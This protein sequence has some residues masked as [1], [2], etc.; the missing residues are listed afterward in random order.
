MK[1]TESQLRKIVKKEC[2]HVLSEHHE[3]LRLDEQGVFAALKGLISSMFG[4]LGDMLTGTTTEYQ[5]VRVGEAEASVGESQKALGRKEPKAWADLK[6]HDDNVDKA[7]WAIAI[8]EG[9]RDFK[10]FERIVKAISLQSIAPPSPEEADEWEQ[11]E[12][13]NYLKDIYK[14]IGEAKGLMEWL[15]VHLDS[16]KALGDSIDD[17]ASLEDLLQQV[18]DVGK[19]IAGDLKSGLESATEA[20]G[21]AGDE[22]YGNFKSSVGHIEGSGEQLTDVS[23]N[24][25]T[26]VKELKEK[27]EE[28]AAATEEG[29]ELEAAAQGMPEAL[30]RKYIR[31]LLS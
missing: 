3:E 2:G 22:Y 17:K 15:G 23:L 24:G 6:P 21:N 26:R 10:I 14:G 28:L 13:A 29:G 25:Y 11:G 5:A 12:D 9:L 1:I 8:V 7:A 31:V 27:A 19:Y 30:L 20:V 16:A 18:A 4:A